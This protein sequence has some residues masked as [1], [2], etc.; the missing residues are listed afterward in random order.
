MFYKPTFAPLH[1]ANVIAIEIHPFRQIFLRVAAL[2]PQG[3]YRRSKQRF[4]RSLGHIPM[5]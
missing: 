2:L 5:V 3:T 4:G 1:A